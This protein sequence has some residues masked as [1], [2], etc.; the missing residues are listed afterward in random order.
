MSKMDY[1][2]PVGGKVLACVDASA[3]ADS[4]VDHA[5][6]A[7]QRL[8]APLTFFHALDRRPQS[9]PVA[10]YSGNIG[11]HAESELLRELVEI[12][13]RRAKIAAAHGRSLI[14][15]ARQRAALSGAAETDGVQ[16]H[17]RLIETM[18]ELEG[19][20]RLFVLGKRGDGAGALH[21]P[22]GSHLERAARSVHR[23]LL[24]TPPA[25]RPIQRF[26]IAFD[27]S[28]T[29]R[30]GVK[31]VAASP[32]LRELPCHL[33]SVTDQPDELREAQAW[34]C[35]LLAQAGF[36]VD[37]VLA[38]GEVDEAMPAL[39]A[40]RDIDLMVMGAYGH[41]R[42]RRMLVGSTTTLML[43]ACPIPVLLLR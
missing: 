5:A 43:R 4:V 29:T 26:A 35:Q 1:E 42:I 37:T 9:A 23:P 33:I 2:I 6:W 18:T 32:L 40:E 36:R 17:G 27:G 38:T 14:E 15:R 8:E 28:A 21:S 39:I 25:F 12:D 41:S 34:A 11:V 19:D 16:R 3:Y 24:V 13:E 30:K 20:V 22:L 7:A 10:D 31:M